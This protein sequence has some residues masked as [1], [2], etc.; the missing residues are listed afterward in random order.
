MTKISLVANDQLLVVAAKPTVSS[1]DQNADI[2]H[3][4]FS[5]EW[6]AFPGKSAVFFTSL[7]TEPYERVLVTY[8][9]CLSNVRSFWYCSFY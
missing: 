9:I 3:V 8:F 6:N 4:N 2:L 1:G 5:A 7:S